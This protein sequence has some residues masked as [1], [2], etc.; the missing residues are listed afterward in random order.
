VKPA[1]PVVE[2]KKKDPKPSGILVTS[3]KPECVM[4]SLDGLL[5]YNESDKHEKTFEVCLTFVDQ[6]KMIGFIVF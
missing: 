5:D 1:A 3:S 6:I 2:A 4:I